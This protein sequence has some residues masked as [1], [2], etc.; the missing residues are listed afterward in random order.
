MFENSRKTISVIQAIPAALFETIFVSITLLLV[1]FIVT[2]EKINIL[3]LVSLYIFAF[4]R[5][6]PIF[7]RFGSYISN[8]RASY[9]SVIL[10]NNEL[11]KLEEYNIEKK[12]LINFL[13][14]RN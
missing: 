9:P 3:P 14:I 2:N 1:A 7:S 4:I 8:L 5:I 10:L 6:L 11:K 13:K 12:K